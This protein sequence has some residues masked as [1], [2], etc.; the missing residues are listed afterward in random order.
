MGFINN[1]VISEKSTETLQLRGV[2][3]KINILGIILFLVGVRLHILY[4]VL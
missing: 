3:S 2:N 4:V 1:D